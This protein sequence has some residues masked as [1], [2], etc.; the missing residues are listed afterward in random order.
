[1]GIGTRMATRKIVIIMTG[2]DKAEISHRG[3]IGPICP[4]VPGA[5]CI[6]TWMSL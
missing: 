6:S 1:M 2:A 3:C 4:E 5:I